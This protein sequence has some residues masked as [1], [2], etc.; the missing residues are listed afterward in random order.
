MLGG[1]V[2]DNRVFLRELRFERGNPSPIGGGRLGLTPPRAPILQRG[3]QLFERLPLP[4]VEQRRLDAVL[5]AEVRHRDLIDEMPP[6]NGGFL[7]RREVPPR[8]VASVLS[9]HR[10]LLA[11]TA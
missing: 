10:L 3:T 11:P 4:E 8:P 5:V 1:D 2:R 6:E 9:T 7:L